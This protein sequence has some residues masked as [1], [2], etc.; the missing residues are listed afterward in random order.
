MADYLTPEEAS[1]RLPFG[2][3]DWI[4]MQLRAGRLRGSKIAGRWLVEASAIA[5][6]VEA[7]SNSTAR[8]RRR[9]AS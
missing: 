5:E 4:R 2:N 9:R 6:M 7:G 3:A 1:S 8:R